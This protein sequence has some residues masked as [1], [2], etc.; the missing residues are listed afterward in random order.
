MLTLPRVED[1]DLV[2]DAAAWN[3]ADWQPIPTTAGEPGHATRF[4]A[5]WSA[6]G[7][8]FG[9]ECS[10]DRQVTTGLPDGGDLWN[11]DV[12]EA[13]FWPDERQSVYLEYE[14]SPAGSELLL[15]VPNRAGEFMGWSPWHFEGDRR[16][17]K[18][19]RTLSPSP[20]TPGEGRGGGDL[21]SRAKPSSSNHPHPLPAYWERGP[22]LS[23]SWAAEF[24]MPFTLF[25]G[26]A[27]VPAPGTIW[28]ANFCRIDHD[29]GSPQLYSWSPGLGSTFH[30]PGRFG[31][32]RF[33]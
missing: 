26:I 4:R 30:D 18:A 32:V 11:E 7:I 33:E 1:F 3:A 24:F 6:T 8:Y 16:T 15:L 27:P 17:R 31:R 12:V 23:A 13:F 29:A 21:G 2:P 5:V 25:R 9:F 22:E 10:D 19:V 28:R 20:G 14:L